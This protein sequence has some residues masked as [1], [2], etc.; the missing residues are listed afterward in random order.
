MDA[1][2][3]GYDAGIAKEAS[4]GLEELRFK[5]FGREQIILAKT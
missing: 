4:S 1:Y 5:R 3:R 2:N